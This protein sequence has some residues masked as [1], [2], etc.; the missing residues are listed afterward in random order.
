MKILAVL[1]APGF[2]GLGEGLRSL[3]VYI[4]IYIYLLFICLYSYLFIYLF[5]HIYIY[6]CVCVCVCVFIYVFMCLFICIY[7]FMCFQWVNLS[8]H[9]EPT[10]RRELRVQGSGGSGALRLRV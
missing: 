10:S 2:Q 5:L 7:L 8:L 3:Y 4:Y 9:R 1:E 6:M